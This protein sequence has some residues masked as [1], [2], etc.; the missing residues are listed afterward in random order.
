MKNVINNIK[1]ELK[2][3]KLIDEDN[4]IINTLK[5]K[6]S[7]DTEKCVANKLKNKGYLSDENIDLYFTEEMANILEKWGER[8]AW[9]E[10][11]HFFHSIQFFELKYPS[12]W[13]QLLNR[14][15]NY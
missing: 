11:Q 14:I 5:D 13:P 10:I 4:D 3:D 6:L 8:N 2:K 15:V 12:Y 7:C 1:P 9:I